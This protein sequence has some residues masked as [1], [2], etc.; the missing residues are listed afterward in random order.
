MEKSLAVKCCQCKT[1]FNYYS[2]KFRP[3][4]SEK[5]KAIDLGTWFEEGYSIAGRDHSVYIEDEEK[6]KKLMDATGETY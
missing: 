4:C 3:F 5:C 2:S 6:L 1:E